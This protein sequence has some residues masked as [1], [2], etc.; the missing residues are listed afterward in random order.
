LKEFQ[1]KSSPASVGGERGGGSGTGSK[2]KRKVKELSQLDAPSGDRDSPDN[3]DSILKALSQSNGVVIPPN[4]NCQEFPDTNGNRSLKE[5]NRPLSSTESLRQISQQL[6]GLVSE[7]T[8]AC[9]VNGETVPS[10]ELESR[11]QE[12][13]AA[14]E[15]SKLTNSQ[16]STKLDQLVRSCVYAYL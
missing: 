12:L 13:A 5:E 11:N 10:G 14:L 16:L 2:K 3:F 9:Y 6:N 8:S 1:Q 15:S 4:G 7:S